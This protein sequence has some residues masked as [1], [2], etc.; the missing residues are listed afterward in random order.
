MDYRAYMAQAIEE[1]K[2]AA[3]EGE[4]PVGAVLAAGDKIIAVAHNLTECRQNPLA[5]AELLAI[6]RAKELLGQ[7]YLTECTLFVTME[8]CPMCAGAI[9]L[10]RLARVVYGCPDSRF[11]ACGSVFNIAEH[12]MSP[13]KP[14]VIGGIM[15][16]E[17]RALLQE[18]FK[19]KRNCTPSTL[20]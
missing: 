8:P 19:R 3:A 1:A 5:H 14:Q 6:D 7:K 11:G 4:V 2:M 10:A 18:F 13:Y 15:E 17:C 16:E 9:V 12:K 20:S